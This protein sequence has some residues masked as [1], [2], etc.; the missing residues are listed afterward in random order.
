MN[1]MLSAQT[2]RVPD[3]QCTDKVCMC[4]S[5][6]NVCVCVSGQHGTVV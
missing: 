6:Q 4:G 5:G 3:V 2:K 1:Q